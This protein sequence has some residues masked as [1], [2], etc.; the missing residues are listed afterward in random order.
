M[1]IYFG[2]PVRQTEAFRLFNINYEKVKYDIEEKHKLSHNI[3]SYSTECYLFD[4]LNNHFKDIRLQI[5]IFNTDKGQCVI[6]YEIKEPSDV[7]DKF[8]NVDQFIIMLSNLKTKFALETKD[9]EMNF[10]EVELEKMEGEPEIIDYP[11]PYI[12]EYMQN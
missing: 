6:G 7:W 4:Y 2:F 1:P 9:Y 8:I 5:R 12:I 3:Y 10:R 11:I